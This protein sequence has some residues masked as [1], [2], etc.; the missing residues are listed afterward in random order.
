MSVTAFLSKLKFSA[1]DA[2]VIFDRDE[3]VG[4][5]TDLVMPYRRWF[6]RGKQLRREVASPAN[7]GDRALPQRS[8]AS[9]F[10]NPS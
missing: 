2:E 4:Q 8:Q 5:P 9:S 3:P 10:S 1:A 7:S 6:G